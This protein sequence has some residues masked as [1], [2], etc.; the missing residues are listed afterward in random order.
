ML[1]RAALTWTC[2]VA[3]AL[4]VPGFALAAPA[5]TNT[6]DNGG[7]SLRNAIAGAASGDTIAVP[8][9]TYTLTSGESMEITHHGERLTVERGDP[10]TRPIPRL[11]PQDPP[12][13]PRGR[14]P[15]RRKRGRFD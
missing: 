4:A 11:A 3:L 10:E 2:A 1:R 8:A 15:Q 5:V 14:A 7:G 13:Q 9:G 6:H 12:S